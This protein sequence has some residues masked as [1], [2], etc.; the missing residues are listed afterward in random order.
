MMAHGI[1]NSIGLGLGAKGSLGA[2]CGFSCSG[3]VT[4]LGRR[5]FILILL[6]LHVHEVV[7]MTIKTKL[8]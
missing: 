7:R 6:I 5:F 4:L 2:S 3:I 8:C 1:A